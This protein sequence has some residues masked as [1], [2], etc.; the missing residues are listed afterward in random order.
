MPY[1][2]KEE[3]KDLK[4]PKTVGQLNY[5]ITLEILKAFKDWEK[6]RIILVTL[7][8]GKNKTNFKFPTQKVLDLCLLY[9]GNEIKYQKINDVTGSLICSG[10]EFIRR[11]PYNMD[12]KTLKKI[13]D[14]VFSFVAKFYKIYAIDY[15]NLCIKKNGDLKE[16]KT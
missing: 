6:K 13:G 3:R 2:K 12:Y 8:G 16:Y 11:N 14:I 9:I 10:F 15:E 5:L 1:I 7:T 4:I